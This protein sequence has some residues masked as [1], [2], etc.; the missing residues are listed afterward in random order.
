MMDGG[1]SDCIE[2]G[3]WNGRWEVNMRGNMKEKGD[4]LFLVCNFRVVCSLQTTRLVVD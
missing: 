2:E 4:K 3:L 1:G